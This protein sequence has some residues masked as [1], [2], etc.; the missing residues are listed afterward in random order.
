M[1][2]SLGHSQITRSP[3]SLGSVEMVCRVIKFFNASASKNIIK[4]YYRNA[5]NKNLSLKPRFFI[6]GR[7]ERIRTFDLMFPKHAR[8]QAAPHPVK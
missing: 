8:Y 4:L 6:D 1:E 7:G 3:R 2:K 5:K